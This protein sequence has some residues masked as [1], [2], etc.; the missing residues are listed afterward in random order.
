MAKIQIT[1]YKCDICNKEFDSEK[2]VKATHIPCYGGERCE[3]H[4]EAQVDLCKD[5]S[6]KL[7]EVIYNNFAR[8]Q[9]YYG[10]HISAK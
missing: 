10:I 7:R 2:D 6:T 8:I 5:C 1:K 9:N 3:Y 4:D